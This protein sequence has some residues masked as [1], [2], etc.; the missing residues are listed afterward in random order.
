MLPEIVIIG[1]GNVATHLA[2]AF[3]N[4]GCHIAQVYSRSLGHAS[5]LAS[6]LKDSQPNEEL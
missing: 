2:H 4:A 3:Q 6:E 5:R 1:A